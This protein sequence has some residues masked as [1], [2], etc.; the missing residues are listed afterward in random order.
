MK[1]GAFERGETSAF[2][3]ALVHDSG[4]FTCRWL[5]LAPEAKMKRAAVFSRPATFTG[6]RT[7]PA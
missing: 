5:M 4:E 1:I 3:H 6:L 7:A 2:V